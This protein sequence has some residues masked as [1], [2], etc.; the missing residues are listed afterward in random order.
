MNI[1]EL[2][3]CWHNLR[4]LSRR[5]F[6]PGLRHQR[7]VIEIPTTFSG[8]AQIIS[9][10]PLAFGWVREFTVRCRRLVAH[11]A[12]PEFFRVTLMGPSVT[13]CHCDAFGSVASSRGSD[14]FLDTGGQDVVPL[15]C[16][17]RSNLECD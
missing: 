11:P 3:E 10:H 17:A 7:R 12:K 2:S 5:W 14:R 15:P 4:L 6:I 8:A 13:L 1:R 9:R 16:L